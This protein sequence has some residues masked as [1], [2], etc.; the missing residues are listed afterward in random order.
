MAKERIG[1]ITARCT[2]G[3]AIERKEI[4][5]S[6][7]TGRTNEKKVSDKLIK[8]THT[9]Q[10]IEQLRRRNQDLAE[11]VQSLTHALQTLTGSGEKR[12]RQ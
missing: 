11:S 1:S 6:A 10:E 7:K 12:T 8:I 5:G 9:I 4:V 2:G 3:N